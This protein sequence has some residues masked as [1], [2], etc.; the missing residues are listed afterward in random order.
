[1]FA[2]GVI[3]AIL[4]LLGLTALSVFP[5]DWLGAGLMVLG[6]I[7]FVLEAKYPTHG[8]LTV[9]GAV[10][11]TLGAVMLVDTNVPEMRVR[12]STA[13]G[14]AVPFALITTFLFSIALRARRNKVV[15]GVEGMIGQTGVAVGALDPAGTILVSGEYWSARATG[16]VSAREPVRITGIDGLT[17]RV[18][19][20]TATKET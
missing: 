20:S 4:V 8:I 12:W 17:L 16:H 18:E 7:F 14:I 2:P 19:P 3:G 13:I 6:L 5:I 15:T 9:G 10:G 1:L 11:L